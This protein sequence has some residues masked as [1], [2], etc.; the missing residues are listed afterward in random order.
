M[1]KQIPKNFTIKPCRCYNFPVACDIMIS[2]EFITYCHACLE[3]SRTLH[4]I[5]IDK[6]RRAYLIHKNDYD[7]SHKPLI[8][9]DCVKTGKL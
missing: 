9:L 6:S 5:C 8:A 3:Y 7:P 2:G 1:K 4:F